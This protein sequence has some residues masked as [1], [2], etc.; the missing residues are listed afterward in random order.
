M[1]LEFYGASAGVTGSCHILR[2]N[3][4]TLLL[5]CGM[6]QG[7]KRL[8]KLNKQPFPFRADSVDAVVLSH[9]HI[10]HSG[11][12]PLL[13]RR[14]FSGNI[15]TQNASRDLCSVLLADSANI[16]ES[17]AR[18]KNRKAKPGVAEVKPLYTKKD[19]ATALKQLRG[20]RYQQWQ[21][22]L[23]GVKVRFQDAG[24]ILGSAVVEL[25]LREGDLQRRLVF[26]GDLG[27]YNTPILRDPQSP[28][29]ADLVLM[30]TTYGGRRHRNRKETIDEIGAI[31]SAAA[32]NKG[33]IL[34][35]AFAIG[36]SQEVLYQLASN[37]EAWG[38]DRFQVFLDSPMAIEA[39]ELYW[40]YPQ[41]YDQD[42]RLIK[43]QAGEMPLLPNLVLSR[44]SDESR[45]INEIKDGAIIIAASG[46]CTG[47]RILH[48]LRNNLA[49]PETQIIIVGYQANGTLGRRLVEG[50]DEVRIHGRTIKARAK[51]HTVGGLSAHGDQDDL[52]RWYEGIEKT[53]AVYLVHGEDEGKNDF[54]E[55]LEQRCGVKAGISKPGLVLDLA[56]ITP[57]V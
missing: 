31:I 37:Y 5:D 51:I 4:H 2:V 23:P 3:G 32:E 28:K 16:M 22:V 41:L 15:W 18:Y 39:S 6:I 53:P 38:V 35:P 54:Q 26:S 55:Y 27:Q 34:I 12:L 14:G 42:A 29:K 46:M 43:Q 20:V 10:D 48:H 25:D 19:A 47:G 13:V 40:N 30:E 9:A 33:N 36:R 8:E 44:T 7:G 49:R 11:R 52:A 57:T 56:K 45:A 21:Q 24:H 1:E 17:D 50:D